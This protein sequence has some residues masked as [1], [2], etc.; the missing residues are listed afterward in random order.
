MSDAEPPGDYTLPI[1]DMVA[2]PTVR[3]P[4]PSS[5]FLERSERFRALAVGHELGPYLRFLGDIATAQARVQ[6]AGSDLAAAGAQPLDRSRTPVDVACAGALEQLL[7]GM[8]A[9]AM[10]EAARIALARLAAAGDA[11]RRDLLRAALD[12]PAPSDSIAEY[13]LLIAA[14]QTVF[15]ARAARIDAAR[16][17]PAPDGAC[18]VCAS[19]PVASLIVGWE[20]SSSTR[21]VACALC[22]TLWNHVRIKCTLCGSTGGIAY[23][24]IDGDAG[25]IKAETCESCH[26]YVKLMQQNKDPVIDPVADDVASLGLDLLMRG[27]PFRRGASNPFLVGY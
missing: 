16:L 3:L 1:V 15:V 10:P 6:G 14:L 11:V 20:G 13:G 8:R 17:L 24:G 23:E 22:G 4:D 27:T 19:P 7:T 18:P 5:L 12:E 25:S 21:Y 26:R 2:P 9:A